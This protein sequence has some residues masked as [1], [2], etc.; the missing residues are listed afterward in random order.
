MHIIKCFSV[1]KRICQ[2]V[3]IGE[4][5]TQNVSIDGHANDTTEPQQTFSLIF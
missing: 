1:E 3:K 2:M 5:R 4:I